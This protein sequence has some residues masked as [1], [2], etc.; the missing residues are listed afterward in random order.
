MS[1]VNQ[2]VFVIVIWSFAGQ[3]SFYFSNRF[4]VIFNFSRFSIFDKMYWNHLL[5]TKPYGWGGQEPHW[6]V[7]GWNFRI[8]QNL[9]TSTLTINRFMYLLV[10][11]IPENSTETSPCWNLRPNTKF[12]SRNRVK[13][14]K[15]HSSM[16]KPVK[17]HQDWTNNWTV[18]RKQNYKKY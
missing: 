13:W 4:M 16:S 5:T 6:T 2:K 17:N 14:N 8:F 10:Y 18:W 1:S 12:W 3:Y 9:F 7:F 11:L 15:N